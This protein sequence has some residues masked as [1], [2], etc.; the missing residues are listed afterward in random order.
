MSSV[1][2]G[3]RT[4][5]FAKYLI[6]FL[7]VVT[8]FF[9][10]FVNRFVEPVLRDRLRTL[11]VRGSDGLYTYELGD[12]D[13]NFFGGNVEVENLHI[14]I[15]SNRYAELAQRHALPSLTFQLDSQKGYVRGLC[16]FALL[17]RITINVE[18]ILYKDAN[19]R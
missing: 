12:L 17:F 6:A 1:K 10:V 15:D 4:R 3:R 8:V 13:A 18:E 11:I 7:L 5:R 16:V 14:R 2:P 19:I 9:V